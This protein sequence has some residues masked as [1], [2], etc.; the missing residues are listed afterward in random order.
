MVKAFS[1]SYKMY[2]IGAINEASIKMLGVSSSSIPVCRLF[3]FDQK[4]R[5]PSG[6]CKLNLIAHYIFHNFVIITASP[7]QH[8][9]RLVHFTLW[10]GCCMC[11]LCAP[12]FKTHFLR[13]NYGTRRLL[14]PFLYVYIRAPDKQRREW[15]P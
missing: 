10:L 13:R 14:F 8:I 4:E 9:I 2:L 11:F 7:L 5:L 1:V 15:H 6:E 3:T 12:P